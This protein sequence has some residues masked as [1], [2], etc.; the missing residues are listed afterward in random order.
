MMNLYQTFQTGLPIPISVVYDSTNKF[1]GLNPIHKTRDIEIGIS[2]AK[3]SHPGKVSYMQIV[4]YT[5]GS[6]KYIT[7]IDDFEIKEGQCIILGRGTIRNCDFE[8]VRAHCVYV[9]GIDHELCKQ[10]GLDDTFTGLMDE[11]DEVPKNCIISIIKAID[12]KKS[13]WQE[14]VIETVKVLLEHI[15]QNYKK[16]YYVVDDQNVLSDKKMNAIDQYITKNISEKIK[17][18]DLAKQVGLRYSQFNKRFKITTGYTPIEYLNMKRCA[19][20]RTL[21]LTTDFDIDDIILM[22]GYCCRSYFYK[23]YRRMYDKDAYKE[24]TGRIVESSYTLKSE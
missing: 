24:R 12:K 10:F 18:E 1:D 15:N 17:L 22:C 20:A 6:S 7:N 8:E 3:Y 4:Y 14:N 16:Y 5:E 23:M 21:L 19:A 2:Y 11:T 9:L 13:G